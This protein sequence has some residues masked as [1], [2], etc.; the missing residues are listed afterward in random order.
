MCVDLFSE[1]V[2]VPVYRP[3]TLLFFSNKG[4]TQFQ[5]EAKLWFVASV[6]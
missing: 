5:A 6:A 3:Q 2:C 4:M 1:S